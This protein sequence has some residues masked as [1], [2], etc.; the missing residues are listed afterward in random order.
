MIPLAPDCIAVAQVDATEAS[1]CI[2]AIW[3]P[4]LVYGEF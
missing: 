3:S 2:F 1:L 4:F